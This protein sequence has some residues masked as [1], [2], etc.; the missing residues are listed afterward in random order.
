MDKFRGVKSF[1]VFYE[2]PTPEQQLKL[3]DYG[4]VIM[5]AN[6][7]TKE[8]VKTIKSKGA[9]V[10]GYLSTMQANEAV[11]YLNQLRTSDYFHVKGVPYRFPQWKSYQM[12]ISQAHYRSILLSE[13]K[14]LIMGLGLDGVFFDTVADIAEK[15]H[16]TANDKAKQHAGLLQLIA[17]IRATNTEGLIIQN[18][19]FHTLRYHS[20]LH[21]DGI[22]WEDFHDA[23]GQ[24]TLD[25][26]QE[27]K[28]IQAL[29]GLT[30]LSDV[31]TQSDFDFSKNASYVPWLNPLGEAG[32]K[33]C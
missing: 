14:R 30:V 7:L 28:N 23:A 13:Y 26:M 22:M 21:V 17:D 29:K 3:A 16:F 18:R 19:G 5:E 25:R 20:C 4:L 12:D 11:P 6:F 27:I 15:D 9:L 24:W 10:V 2:N 1:R 8:M 31:K 33:I 32:Y